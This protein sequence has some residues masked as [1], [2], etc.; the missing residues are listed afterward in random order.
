MPTRSRYQNKINDLQYKKMMYFS[1]NLVTTNIDAF[2]GTLVNYFPKNVFLSLKN[3]R[4]EQVGNSI[5]SSTL[6][7]SKPFRIPSRAN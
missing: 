5:L 7:C 3:V 6:V 1:K 2:A 4:P